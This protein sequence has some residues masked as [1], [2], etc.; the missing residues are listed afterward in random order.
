MSVVG[1]VVIFTIVW[2][3]A[4]F[5]LLPVGVRT[6]ESVDPGHA[7]SAPERPR[8]VPKALAATAAAALVTF[9]LHVAVRQGWISFWDVLVGPG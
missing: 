8:L 3:L 4:F 1:G 9:G 5:M 7:A 2:W 6:A